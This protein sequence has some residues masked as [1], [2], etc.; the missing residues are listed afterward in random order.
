MVWFILENNRWK[1]ARCVPRDDGLRSIP[2]N[3]RISLYLLPDERFRK[4]GSFDKILDL[5]MRIRIQESISAIT[6]SRLEV[7][8]GAREFVDLLHALDNH[9]DSLAATDARRGQAISSAAPMQLEKQSKHEPCAGRLSTVG[10]ID[11]IRNGGG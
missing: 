1:F 7:P 2:L 11:V 8:A 6:R 9:R 3:K 10:I 4:F 5:N